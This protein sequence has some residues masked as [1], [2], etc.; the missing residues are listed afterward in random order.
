M[1]LKLRDG[2]IL[3][4]QQLR[5]HFELFFLHLGDELHLFNLVEVNLFSHGIDNFLLGGYEILR[6]S[7]FD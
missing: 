4:S 3:F 5:R 1:L 7:F 2:G 6:S